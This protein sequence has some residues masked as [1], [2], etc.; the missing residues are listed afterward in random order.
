MGILM[1]MLFIDASITD[2][3]ANSLFATNQGKGNFALFKSKHRF[4][5]LRFIYNPDSHIQNKIPIWVFLLDI[6][7]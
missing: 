4:S 2:K 6:K 7:K 5:I 1:A 3:K